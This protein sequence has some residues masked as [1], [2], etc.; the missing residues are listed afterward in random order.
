MKAWIAAGA[1]ALALAS[2]S[3]AAQEFSEA[4]NIVVTAQRYASRYEEFSIPHVMLK[5]R[6]DFATRALTVVSDTRD[7]SDRMNELR[8]ALRWMER[9]ASR[10]MALG[11]IREEEGEYGDT[12]VRTFTVETA[13]GAVRGGPR[14]DT[15][16]VMIVVRTPIAADDSLEAIERRFNAFRNSAP[17]PGRV[18]ILSGGFDLVLIN[19]AQY[20]APIIDEIVAD[21]NRV[22]SA[23]GA[24]YAARLEQLENAIAWRRSG[25]LELALYIPYRLTI[26]PIEAD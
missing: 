21:A 6:A 13:M 8:E 10:A 3:A 17:K 22:I 23:L 26:L 14:P 5:R 16:Q 15:S 19:P 12:R 18:E 2:S 1:A 20:R 4:D 24:G 25:D 11:V 9:Q 7:Y